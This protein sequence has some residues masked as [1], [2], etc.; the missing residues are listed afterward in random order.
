MGLGIETR[1]VQEGI[2]LMTLAGE[3]DPYSFE[4]VRQEIARPLMA[5]NCRL[6]LDVAG[7]RYAGRDLLRIIAD[8]LKL[9]RR[10]GGDLKVV[11]GEN[12]HV[13]RLLQ[14]HGFTALVSV[15]GTTEAAIAEL[16]GASAEEESAP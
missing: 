12:R 7:L 4:D 11:T 10:H 8:A 13:L 14:F 15:C 2:T 16:T 3:L 5:G 6:V 1:R 9:T